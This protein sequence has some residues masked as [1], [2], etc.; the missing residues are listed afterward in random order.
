MIQSKPLGLRLLIIGIA[1][2]EIFLRYDF[3]SEYS[4]FGAGYTV[5]KVSLLI[6]EHSHHLEEFQK[7]HMSWRQFTAPKKPHSQTPIR[8]WNLDGH[9]NFPVGGS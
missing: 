1:N 6:Y 2:A 7:E 5:E 9:T 8:L 3:F 4:R